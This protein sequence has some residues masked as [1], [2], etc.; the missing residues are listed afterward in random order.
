MEIRDA[1]EA[2]FD[3]VTAIYNEILTNSTAIYNDVPVSRANRLEL[4]QSRL[5]LGYPMLV[6]VDAGQ[7]LGFATFGDFRPWPG[8]R[9]TVEGTIHIHASARGKGVG[10]QL[11]KQLVERAA[12][13]G[14]HSILAGVD[15]GNEASLRFLERFGFRHVAYFPEVGYKFGR[16]LNLRFLQY[17][18]TP[19][20]HSAI[21]DFP[22]PEPHTQ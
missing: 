19:P 13:L 15:S 2:D 21:A 4:W 7:I 9:F 12:A 5:Q 17:W 20:I 10:T 8:Y 3:E 1:V 14:K 16:F 6:A 11:L 22:A 18:L